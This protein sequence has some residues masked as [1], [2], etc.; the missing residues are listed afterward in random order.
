[1]TTHERERAPRSMLANT[2]ARTS[3]RPRL[4]YRADHGERGGRAI[5][6][7]ADAGGSVSGWR[8][9]RVEGGVWPGPAAWRRRSV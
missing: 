7:R 2:L 4:A 6:L 5:G 9:G 1:M 3:V 8:G